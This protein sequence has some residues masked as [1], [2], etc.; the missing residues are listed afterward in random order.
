MA[1]GNQ[2]FNFF[3]IVIR[4]GL[5]GPI[6]DGPGVGGGRDEYHPESVLGKASFSSS[7]PFDVRYR[8]EKWILFTFLYSPCDR[9]SVGLKR[10]IIKS[11]FQWP[12]ISRHVSRCRHQFGG[13]VVGGGDN[14]FVI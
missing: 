5:S 10:K 8:D 11:A 6:Y 2:I 4:N 14:A 7:G 13:F 3:F 1:E 12:V 9:P